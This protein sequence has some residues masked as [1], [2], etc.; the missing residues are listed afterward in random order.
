VTEPIFEQK[1]P[2][3]ADSTPAESLF[4]NVYSRLKAMASRQQFG[5]KGTL[6]TTALVHEL[7]LK[8]S[9]GD[10]LRFAT[11]EQFFDYAAQAMRHILVDRARA[12]V[13]SK[14]GGGAVME[15]ADAALSVPDATAQR[16][17]E[18]DDALRRLE[19]RDPRAARFVSLHYFAGLP[20]ND[21]AKLFGVTPRTL[22]RDW[23]FA[24]AFLYDALG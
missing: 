16:T 24:R 11:D 14:R 21:I 6:N 10:A 13:T 15:S 8:L 17:L 19:Q 18:L 23:R 1:T 9:A 20:L 3:A 12:R 4:Q 2:A 22:N 7:Y 5:E